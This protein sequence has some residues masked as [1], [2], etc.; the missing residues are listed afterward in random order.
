MAF[1][2]PWPDDF[3]GGRGGLPRT[4]A[5]DDGP[6]LGADVGDGVL[7]PLGGFTQVSGMPPAPSAQ[8]ML[9]LSGPCCNLALGGLAYGLGH[10]F[11]LLLIFAWWNVLL[12]AFNLIPAPPLDGGAALRAALHAK[13]GH[14]RGDLWAGRIG[15]AAGA[16]AIVL[17]IMWGRPLLVF[18]GIIAGAYSYDLFRQSRFA[19]YSTRP[20]TPE[21]GDFRTWRL[22]RKK[23]DAEITRKQ[24][25]ERADK[26]VRR[27]VDELLKQISEKGFD[28]LGEE[29]RAFL[30]RAGERLRRPDR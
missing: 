29:D 12:G 20:R 22:P 11:P 21:T 9:S 30:R 27:K 10:L 13:I 28:S 15:I 17:G 8:I 7:G 25:I 5:R 14:A 26:E 23:L 24:K 3:A 18:V 2:Q 6:G 16:A 1:V 4:G 19:G